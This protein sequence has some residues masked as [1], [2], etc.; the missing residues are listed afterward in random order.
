[1]PTSINIDF[2]DDDPLLNRFLS[3]VLEGRPSRKI[4]RVSAEFCTVGW[5]TMG[6]LLHPGNCRRPTANAFLPHGWSGQNLAIQKMIGTELLR[7]TIETVIFTGKVKK[8]EPVSLL[9]IAAPESGKT[10]VVLEKKCKSIEAYTDITGRGIH[11]IL[12]AKKDLTHI[13]IND[14]VASL[15]HKQ[16]VNKYLISQL[17]AMTEEGISA[18]ATPQGIETFDVGK[19]GIITSLTLDLVRDSR[20]WWSRIGF[21]SRMLPFCYSYRAGMIVKIKSS[22]DD[23]QKNGNSKVSSENFPVPSK[24][25]HVEYPENA[26]IEVRR[27]ADVRSIILKEQG[28]R[29][30]KQYHALAQ[31]HAA[32]RTRKNP[33][34]NEKDIEFLRRMDAYVS[35]DTPEPL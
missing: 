1:M 17:S 28:M 10:S 30:L 8:I 13:V 23:S 35:Y 15:S 11:E 18:I 7:E 12:K 29:R 34:V 22:I 9:L 31:A 4:L 14:M 24:S 3:R 2:F 33:T 16:S 25:L 5:R 21:T 26:I 6:S 32:L 27:M 19:R 20:H